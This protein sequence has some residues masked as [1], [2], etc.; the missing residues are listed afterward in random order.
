MSCHIV[1]HL[2]SDI[3]NT[4]QRDNLGCHVCFRPGCF[5]SA[6]GCHAKCRRFAH[7]CRTEADAPRCSSCDKVCHLDNSD[8]RCDFFGQTRGTLPL[9]DDV[10]TE[11][12]RDTEAGTQGSLPHFSQVVWTFTDGARTEL[13]VDGMPYRKG[14]G[15][16]GDASIGELNNC[17]IDSLRQTLDNL[18]CDRKLVRKDLQ[19]EFGEF[20][21]LEPRRHVTH[22]SYLDVEFHWRS[23]LRSL[24]R[25]NTSGREHICD[26]DD[27]RVVALS[28][29][30]PGNG[31][32]L[33]N[34]DARYVLVVINWGDVHFDPCFPIIPTV[35]SGSIETTV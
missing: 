1:T 13:I 34:R 19:R 30:V 3:C 35:S 24:F 23:V 27:Y 12:L 31:V 2:N 16:P 29:N 11:Q 5:A 26:I 9:H 14:Y 8:P 21:A 15:Y 17:L 28:G 33:G 4:V 6:P 20:D 32:V 22:G 10:D 7:V 18:Q 25:H